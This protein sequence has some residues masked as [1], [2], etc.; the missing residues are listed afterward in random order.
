MRFGFSQRS[1]VPLKK[2]QNTMKKIF[3]KDIAED[4][5][6]SK[7]TVSLVLNNKGD[8]NKISKATQQRIFA[9]AEKHNYVPNQLARGL[10]R[11]ISETIGLIIPNISDIFYA[12]IASSVE[13]KAKSFG[14]TVI[15]SSSNEDPQMETELI[16]SM[17][18]RQ[19]DGLVIAST[20][21]KSYRDS[22]FEKK[23]CSF[24]TDRSALSRQ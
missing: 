18:H 2:T 22:G 21:K 10:S 11:G 1:Y 7:T 24:R 6:V 3:L 8:E 5:N 14:Y 20:Q 9:Y 15:Y 4:L 23:Q 17:L 16:R 19:V 12:K 13:K